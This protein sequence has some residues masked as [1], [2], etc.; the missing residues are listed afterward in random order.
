M[1]P[2]SSLVAISA[3]TPSISFILNVTHHRVVKEGAAPHKREL[4]AARERVAGELRRGSRLSGKRPFGTDTTPLRS[5]GHAHARR[6]T[7][8]DVGVARRRKLRK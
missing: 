5:S 7:V 3:R 1:T 4:A 2:P 8:V 6:L